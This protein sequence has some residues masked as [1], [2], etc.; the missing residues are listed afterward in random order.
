MLPLDSLLGHPPP[1]VGPRAAINGMRGTQQRLGV[2]P[3]VRAA[4]T[5]R[6]GSDLL[7]KAATEQ[8]RG[9]VRVG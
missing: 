5:R 3:S 6:K 7:I 1:R 4:R 8:K 2:G 9:R